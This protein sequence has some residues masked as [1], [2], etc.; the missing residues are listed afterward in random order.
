MDQLSSASHFGSLDITPEPPKKRRHRWIWVVILLLFGL[1]FYWVLH[2]HYTSQ[3]AHGRRAF[4][5]T[6][7]VT[8]VTANQGSIGVYL[9]AIGTVTPVYTVSITSQVTG[10][11]TAVHYREGQYVQKGDPLIDIDDRTYQAQ[12]MQAE[13]TLERDQNVLAEAQMD[14]KRYQA[15][16]AKN[17]I[18]RQTLDDQEKL[19]LQEQGLVKNDQGAVAYRAGAG[20][21]LPH[22]IADQRAR[23]TAA[24]GSRKPGDGE[25]HD[26]ADSGDADVANHGDF[27][28]C[29]RRPER[30]AA[31]GSRRTPVDRRG[32]GFF[33]QNVLSTGKLI[34]V[35]N[36]IDTMT[37]TVKLRAQFPNTKGT[38][39]PNQFVN[40][41]LLVKTLD[42]Q[43]LIPA[44]GDPAQRVGQ[45]RL[46]D[47][48]Q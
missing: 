39:F 46:F 20:G 41:R 34:S 7:P 33:R 15:A 11:I 17:A 22:Q 26:H 31:T 42:K 2:Q 48:E 24:G 45:L 5:G 30:R 8:E 36:Q 13:G 16:W 47:P 28:R 12:L 32:A 3:A 44:F 27:H 35:D 14:L 4:T 9:N 43:T 1:L 18:P 23:R 19:V 10:V 38:L 37:G 40:T 6:V 25:L 29:R 21:V